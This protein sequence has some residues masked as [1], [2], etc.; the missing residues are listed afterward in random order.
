MQRFCFV[1]GFVA[2]DNPQL[3]LEGGTGW[4]LETERGPMKSVRIRFER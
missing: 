4:A 3:D 1:G 2:N